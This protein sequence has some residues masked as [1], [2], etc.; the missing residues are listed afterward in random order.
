MQ[1]RMPNIRLKQRSGGVYHYTFFHLKKRYR[2]TTRQVNTKKAMEVAKRERDLVVRRA[3]AA[4]KLPEDMTPQE[5][6]DL[7]YEGLTKRGT[8]KSPSTVKN[9]EKYA[10]RFFKFFSDTHLSDITQFQVEQWRAWLLQQKTTCYGR[11]NTL[12]AKTTKEH[13][14]WL[15]AIYRTFKF[16]FNP[17]TDVVRPRKTQIEEQEDLSFYDRGDLQNLIKTAKNQAI[18]AKGKGSFEEFSCVLELLALTGMRIGEARGIRIKDIDWDDNIIFV[19]SEKT[20]K[21]RPLYLA[22]ETGERGC[23]YLTYRLIC[24][25]IRRELSVE[26]QNRLLGGSLDKM[27]LPLEKLLKR[28]GEALRILTKER[29]ELRLVPYGTT[30]FYKKLATLCEKCDPPI[31]FLGVH[32]IRHTF[33]VRAMRNP[34][35]SLGF[36]SKWLGH[37]SVSFT[38]KRYGHLAKEKRPH[39]SYDD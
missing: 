26:D 31:P 10:E 20:K 28:L 13:I 22:D 17:C 14:E 38:I 33:V 27:D 8:P 12:S 16:T 35:W 21:R 4:G 25:A 39:F 24:A 19:V 15:S 11:T 6:F 9:Y 23:W 29:P 7:Y 30:W 34:E 36:L 32:A 3:T 2:G 37:E 5:L 1:K 18:N